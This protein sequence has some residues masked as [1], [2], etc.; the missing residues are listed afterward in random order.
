MNSTTSRT[1]TVKT[2]NRVRWASAN[3]SP[4]SNAIR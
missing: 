1:V 4:T 2:V 3:A